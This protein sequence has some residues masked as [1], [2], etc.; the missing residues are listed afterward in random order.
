MEVKRHS[1]VLYI[2]F[3]ASNSAIIFHCRCSFA[4]AAYRD[5]SLTFNRCF[6]I[7]SQEEGQPLSSGH[8][9]GLPG[10]KLAVTLFGDGVRSLRLG[11]C[12]SMYPTFFSLQ[13]LLPEIV[14]SRCEKLPWETS[15]FFKHPSLA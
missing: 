9:R 2:Y 3:Q 14:S 10:K 11:R 15:Y 13:S 6:F 7:C 5:R 1:K 4:E 12:C 8:L